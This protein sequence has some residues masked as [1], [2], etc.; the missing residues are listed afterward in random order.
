MPNRILKESVCTSDKIDR[1]SWFEEVLFYRLIVNCDDYGR[2]DG[3]AAIIKNR[4]FPLK[5]GITMESVSEAVKKLAQVGL[6]MLYA[7]EEKPFLC[8]PTWNDHQNVRAK[9]S[10]YPAPENGCC[11]KTTCADSCLQ[12]RADAPDILSVSESISVS[13]VRQIG[14]NA[15]VEH[16]ATR[17]SPPTVE[18]VRAYCAERGNGIDPEAFVDYYAARGWKVGRDGMKD[19]RAAVRT[20]EHRN[21][22]AYQQKKQGAVSRHTDALTDLER[23]AVARMLSQEW[24]GEAQ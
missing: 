3:R 17:F 15:C 16:A 7:C 9:R 2:F 6:V 1:L 19:W 12:L 24:D 23:Q 11:E 10:K 4:L 14:E 5:E 20:W 22:A 21:G 13:S 8:L 18:D